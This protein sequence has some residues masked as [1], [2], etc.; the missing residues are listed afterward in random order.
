MPSDNSRQDAQRCA[1]RIPLTISALG[2]FR[3]IKTTTLIS[4]KQLT[5]SNL[6]VALHVGTLA[7][8]ASIRNRGDA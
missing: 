3:V 5:H 8:N 1:T 2:I 6:Q 4:V 7:K